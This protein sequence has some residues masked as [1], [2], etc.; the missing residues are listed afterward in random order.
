M[1]VLVCGLDCFALPSATTACTVAREFAGSFHPALTDAA[2]AD[3]EVYKLERVPADAMLAEE[4]LVLCRVPAWKFDLAALEELHGQLDGLRAE[5][6]E[7]QVS[8]A[9]TK[10]A[11]IALSAGSE[12]MLASQAA[13][14]S[15]SVAET[16]L[17]SSGPMEEVQQLRQQLAL[18]ERNQQ[19]TKATVMALRSEF[20]HLIEVW[21]GETATSR[22]EG[23]AR[24][25]ATEARAAP[26]ATNR[27]AYDDVF[28]F[29]QELKAYRSPPYGSFGT[30]LIDDYCNELERTARMSSQPPLAAN[31]RRLA[32][33]PRVWA[34]PSSPI[35]CGSPGYGHGYGHGVRHV[36]Q[37]ATLPGGRPRSLGCRAMRS[38][39]APVGARR[40]P[41]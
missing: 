19:E 17:K 15:G 5:H 35:G 36:R 41:G 34:N 38:A 32:G 16:A 7:L 10:E 40:Q 23:E 1:P 25:G 28:G 6:E 13:A 12:A 22:Q 31:P 11:L 24:A 21:G 2:A 14:D 26:R 33:S 37:A 20:M 3:V 39:G 8:F 30:E 29:V 9:R 4:D 27:G 18:S